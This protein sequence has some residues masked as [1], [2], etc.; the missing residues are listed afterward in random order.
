M[1]EI[2]EMSDCNF[3]FR[4][5][6]LRASRVDQVP[7]LH[8]G[9][10]DSLVPGGPPARHGLRRHPLRVRLPDLA[11]APRLVWQHCAQSRAAGADPG[12]FGH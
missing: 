7:A 2:L 11:R 4:N 6:S 8:R 10:D 9:R 3:V 1:Y 12:M 5:P